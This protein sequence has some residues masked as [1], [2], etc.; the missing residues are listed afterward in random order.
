MNGVN[1]ITVHH[2]GWRLVYF[3]DY[4]TTAERLETIRASHLQRMGAGDIGYHY[5]IDRA[6]RLWEGRDLRYQGAHVKEQNPHNIGI[7]LLGNFDQQSPS[8][9]QMATLKSTLITLMR[10]YKVPAQRVYTHREL[11]NS[12]CPGTQLQSRITAWRK[13]GQLR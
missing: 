13:S 1:R 10:A 9:A 12:Q 5:I 6:G 3:T 4:R 11:H 7:M 2:E 8:D